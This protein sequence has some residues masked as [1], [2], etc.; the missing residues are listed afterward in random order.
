METM[1]IGT[2]KRLLDISGQLVGRDLVDISRGRGVIT[3]GPIK[4]ITEIDR[5]VFFECEW[6]ASRV[7]SVDDKWKTTSHVW[8][9]SIFSSG[10]MF[11]Y[12][13]MFVISTGNDMM[14]IM[15]VEDNISLDQQ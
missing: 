1:R 14:I 3:R 11:E 7:P 2:C 8:R 9:I 10:T 15:P 13:D 6:S 4:R 12:K 5:E